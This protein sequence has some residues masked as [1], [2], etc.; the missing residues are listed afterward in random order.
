MQGLQWV[1]SLGWEYALE[2]EMATHSSILAWRIP[3]TE[4]PGG[5]Q[6]MGLQRVGHDRATNSFTFF[7]SLGRLETVV[8]TRMVFLI[9]NSPPWLIMAFEYLE[10]GSV[11][12]PA[13]LARMLNLTLLK[14]IQINW[15]FNILKNRS[16]NNSK[17]LV[18]VQAFSYTILENLTMSAIFIIVL[19][20]FFRNSMIAK[21]WHVWF[22]DSFPKPKALISVKEICLGKL[23][24]HRK[25][26]EANFSMGLVVVRCFCFFYFFIICYGQ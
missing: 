16:I 17:A 13:N 3:W 26:K 25:K 8:A 12:W 11:N 20:L 4:E 24:I 22:D 1:W 9:G 7:Y 10:L 21:Y 5:L 2:K 23:W 18:T 19:A 15:N 14:A 6:S